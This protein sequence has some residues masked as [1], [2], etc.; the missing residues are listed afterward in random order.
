MIIYLSAMLV[1]LDVQWWH[2]VLALSRIATFPRI[3]APSLGQEGWKK[4]GILDRLK[5]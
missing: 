2:L 5:L 3:Y 1:G 4:E